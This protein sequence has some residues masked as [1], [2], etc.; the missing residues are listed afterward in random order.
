MDPFPYEPLAVGVARRLRE[1]L[2]NGE[3]PPG[4]HLVEADLAERLGVSRG[5][6]REAIRMLADQGLVEKLP[7]RGTRVSDF[8]P[9]DVEEIYS[10][11]ALLEGFAIER[12]LA[13]D[14]ADVDT[15]VDDLEQLTDRMRA[16]AKDQNLAEFMDYDLEFHTTLVRRSGHQRLRALWDVL[17]PQVRRMM[18]FTDRL[19]GDLGTSAEIHVPVLQALR[20][21]DARAAALAVRAHV[22]ESGRRVL[23]QVVRLREGPSGRS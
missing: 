2:L 3:L 4:T 7:R 18:V 22:Q 9:A 8:S 21:R 15:V 23:T 11:R 1:A 13:T 19:F 16:A 20:A 6:V 10:L 14:G 17:S 5:P 12:L